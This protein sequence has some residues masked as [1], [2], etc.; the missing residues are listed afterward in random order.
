[1]T[2]FAAF[3]STDINLNCVLSESEI[4]RILQI[5]EGDEPTVYRV[6]KA[7]KVMDKDK[8]GAVS[9]P[10]WIKYLCNGTEITNYHF[11]K[12]LRISF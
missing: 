8:S 9:L 1:M 7:L 5:Y 12:H 2:I 10:E 6:K 11:R 4:A 3:E